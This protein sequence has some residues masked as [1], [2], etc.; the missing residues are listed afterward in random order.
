MQFAHVTKSEEVVISRW[1]SENETQ[2]EHS[3]ASGSTC[4][5]LTALRRNIPPTVECDAVSMFLTGCQS[6]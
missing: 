6:S 3:E 2:W 1:N 5:L 4:L